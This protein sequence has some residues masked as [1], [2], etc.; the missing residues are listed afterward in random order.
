MMIQKRLK[1][2]WQQ[3]IGSRMTDLKNGLAKRENPEGETGY[4]IV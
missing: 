4:G 1:K 3:Q 2:Y